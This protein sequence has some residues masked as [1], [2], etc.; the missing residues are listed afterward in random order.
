MKQFFLQG[1]FCA[2]FILHSYLCKNTEFSK[3]ICEKMNCKAKATYKLEALFDSSNS[4]KN[5]I[6]SDNKQN[7]IRINIMDKYIYSY[8]HFFD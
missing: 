2:I 4:N 3:K 8:S 6:T 1:L 5:N 7:Y